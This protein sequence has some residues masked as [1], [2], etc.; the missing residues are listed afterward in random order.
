VQDEV[1][2]LS[3][4]PLRASFDEP[5]TLRVKGKFKTLASATNRLAHLKGLVS[6]LQPEAKGN[7]DIGDARKQAILGLGL[8]AMAFLDNR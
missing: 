1:L 3:R 4:E 6:R 2:H 8:P 7:Q 5:L